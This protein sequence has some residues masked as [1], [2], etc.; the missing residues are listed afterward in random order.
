MGRKRTGRKGRGGERRRRKTR[1]RGRVNRRRTMGREM[2]GRGG[3]K[4]G[5]F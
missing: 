1:G 4:M 3:K 5:E 2:E